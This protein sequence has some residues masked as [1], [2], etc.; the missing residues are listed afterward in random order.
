MARAAKVC[1][2]PGCFEVTR[3]SH[4]PE[5]APKPW[6]TGNAGRSRGGRPWMRQ[7]AEVFQRD[8]YS[9]VQ[10]GHHDPTAASLEC[11]HDDDGGLRTLCRTCHRVRTQQQAAKAR[12][13]TFDSPD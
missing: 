13:R 1:A 11:D 4:C 6:S 2:Q 10:C 7:R 3:A 12:W 8:D 9:C 5:H